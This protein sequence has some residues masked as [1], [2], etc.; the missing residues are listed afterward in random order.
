MMTEWVKNFGHFLDSQ[1]T[2]QSLNAVMKKDCA[3]QLERPENKYRSA[4]I[5]KKGMKHVVNN[6]NK[7]EELDGTYS[8]STKSDHECDVEEYGR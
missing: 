5:S 4:V 2:L 6:H 1:I 7:K 8:E 3:S